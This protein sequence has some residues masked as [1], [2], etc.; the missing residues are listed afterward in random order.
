MVDTNSEKQN[1]AI[2]PEI[3]QDDAYKKWLERHTSDSPFGKGVLGKIKAIRADVRRTLQGQ[4]RVLTSVQSSDREVRQL[5]EKE[6]EKFLA[7]GA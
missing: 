1:Q 6:I 2:R 3:L 7:R 5:L 4:D